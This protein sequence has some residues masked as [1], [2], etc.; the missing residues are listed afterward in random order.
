MPWTISRSRSTKLPFSS[1]WVAGGLPASAELD[2]FKIREALG[3]IQI[4]EPNEDFSDL[5]YRLYG[6]KLVGVVG[7]DF[8]GLWVSEIPV[9]IRALLLDQYLAVCVQRRPIYS[10]NDTKMEFFMTTRLYRLILPM[11]GADCMVDRVIVSSAPCPR[12]N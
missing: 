9:G 4:L 8:T 2:P 1:G 10:E 7:D 12:P 5:F 6:T 11:V 3:F